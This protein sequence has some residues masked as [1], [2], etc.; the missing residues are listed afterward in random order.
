MDQIDNNEKRKL[1]SLFKNIESQAVTTGLN[2]NQD[3]DV[4]IV[5][6]L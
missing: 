2:K 3:S 5:D 1:Y 6:G 4:L